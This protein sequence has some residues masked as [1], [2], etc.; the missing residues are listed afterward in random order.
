MDSSKYIKLRLTQVFKFRF[1]YQFRIFHHNNNYYFLLLLLNLFVLLNLNFIFFL[2]FSIFKH[3]VNYE[4]F[5]DLKIVESDNLRSSNSNCLSVNLKRI[6]SVNSI[7]SN[8]EEN[9]LRSEVE[10]SCE[11][12]LFSLNKLIFQLSSSVVIIKIFTKA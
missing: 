4:I 5:T 3:Q 8:E 6:S 1:S 11:F 2:V 10:E 7:L 12:F 9:S